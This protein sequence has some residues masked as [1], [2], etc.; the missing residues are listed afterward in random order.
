MAITCKKCTSNNYCK[1]GTVRGLQRYKCKSCNYNFTNT[2]IRGKSSEQRALAVL[3]YGM[4]KSSFRWLGK[5]F[6]VAHT[7]VY[8][9][10]IQYGKTLPKSD[11]P[12]GL[13]EVEID[14]MW[15]FVD[16]KK[17]RYGYGKPIVENSHELLDGWSVSVILKPLKNYGT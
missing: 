9:W 10:I 16:S 3:L 12:E 4:G 1:N 8:K 17:T 5:L 11:I 7:T 2:A 14:E 13:Q 6:K 15:H